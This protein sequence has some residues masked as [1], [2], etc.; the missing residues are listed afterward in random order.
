MY[1]III[2]TYLTWQLGLNDKIWKLHMGVLN[3]CTIIELF[4]FSYIINESTLWTNF[5]S[6]LVHLPSPC[7]SVWN[8]SFTTSTGKS[9]NISSRGHRV[10]LSYL[11]HRFCLSLLF[12]H[13]TFVHIHKFQCLNEIYR[14]LIIDTPKVVDCSLRQAPSKTNLGKRLKRHW[15]EQFKDKLCLEPWIRAR[16]LCLGSWRFNSG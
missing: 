8:F 13:V 3:A 4:L 1:G 11:C 16:C 10:Q 14:L 6:F 9:T 12:I 7:E 2:K 5:S 15:E